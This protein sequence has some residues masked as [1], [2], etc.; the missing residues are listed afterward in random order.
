MKMNARIPTENI[1]RR[2]VFFVTVQ[3][4]LDVEHAVGDRV[5]EILVLEVVAANLDRPARRLVL[6]PERLEVPDQLALLGLHGYHRLVGPNP[7]YCLAIFGSSSCPGF[8]GGSETRDLSLEQG[9][10]VSCHDRRS[11]PTS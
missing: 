9:N 7:S 6:P 8:D 10:S 1:A 5:P 4:G 11:I 3:L 2:L